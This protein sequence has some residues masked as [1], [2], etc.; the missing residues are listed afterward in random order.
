MACT[1]QARTAGKFASHMGM[2][3]DDL[4]IDTMITLYITNS[5]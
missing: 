2:R 4:D 3:D 1:F 5:D